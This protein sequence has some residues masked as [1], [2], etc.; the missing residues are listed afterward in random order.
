MLDEIAPEKRNRKKQRAGKYEGQ[1]SD[2][3]AVSRRV[4]ESQNIHKLEGTKKEHQVQ[5]LSEE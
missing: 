5:L 1:L 2:W 4:I 3:S